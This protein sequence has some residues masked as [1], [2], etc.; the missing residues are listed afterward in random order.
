MPSTVKEKL[1]HQSITIKTVG[2]PSAFG[3]SG[4]R[5]PFASE[6]KSY[7][8]FISTLFGDIIVGNKIDADVEVRQSGEYVNNVVVQIYRDGKPIVQ[9]KQVWSGGGSKGKSPEERKSIEDQVRIYVIADLWKADKLKETDPLV[10]KMLAWLGELP[11]ISPVSKE[12]IPNDTPQPKGVVTATTEAEKQGAEVIH[13]T[14]KDL[15]DIVK[16]KNYDTSNVTAIIVRHFKKAKAS[17]LSQEQV[18]EL[19]NLIEDGKLKVEK[20]VGK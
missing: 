14:V 3:T 4:Q 7:V 19:Y 20:K 12:A 2:K 10:G 1:S 17:E 11:K 5:I 18:D 16:E 13:R 9:P 15:I 6:D 8:C